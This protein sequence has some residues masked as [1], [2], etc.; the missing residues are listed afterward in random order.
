MIGLKKLLIIVL[1]LVA[2]TSTGFMFYEKNKLDLINKD[3]NDYELEIKDLNESISNFDIE[4]EQVEKE[5][6]ENV[7][8]NKLKLYEVWERQNKYLDQSL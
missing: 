1:V 3:I 4:K 6:K 2:L 8:E 5:I 7:D